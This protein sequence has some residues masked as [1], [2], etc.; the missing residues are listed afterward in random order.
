M[1]NKLYSLMFEYH[2]QLAFGA[3]ELKIMQQQTTNY[4]LI[5][6]NIRVES[7]ANFAAQNRCSWLI[8]TCD[9]F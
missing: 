1:N 3:D 6:D 7:A 4:Y 5:L 2:L 8:R 9:I